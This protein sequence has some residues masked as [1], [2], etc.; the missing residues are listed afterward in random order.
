[1]PVENKRILMILDKYGANGGPNNSQM[2]IAKSPLNTFYEFEIVYYDRARKYLNPLTFIRFVREIKKKKA[3]IVHFSGLQLDGYIN[4]LACKLAGIKKIIIAIRGSSNEAIRISKFKRWLFNK[5]EISTL[6]KA[7]MTYGVSDYVSNWDNVKRF[8]RHHFGTIYNLGEYDSDNSK[9]YFRNEFG[10]PNDAFVVVSTGRIIEEKGFDVLEKVIRKIGVKK[11]LYFVIVGDGNFKEQMSYNLKS[12]SNV[13]FTGYRKDVLNILSES[14]SFVL[15]T[16]HETLGNSIIEALYSK[17]PVIVSNV[18]GIPEYVLDGQNGFLVNPDDY[19][20]FAQHIL[21]LYEDKKLL[22]TMKENT[23]LIFK[24]IDN[25]RI[26]EQI[27]KMY[28]MCLGDG[29]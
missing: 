11:D 4:C 12:F 29:R 17:L 19:D 24:M 28:E 16:K 22:S 18:G 13:I 1:M 5:L 8:S 14:D 9:K 27:K 6:K 26:I 25:S 2:R 7:T 3:S 15:C 23:K 21:N 10:I 20:Q